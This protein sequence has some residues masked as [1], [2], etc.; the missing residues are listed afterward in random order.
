MKLSEL[1]REMESVLKKEGDL[2][3]WCEC[4]HGQ[5]PENVYQTGVSYLIEDGSESY[6]INE[7]DLKEYGDNYG[8]QVQRIFFIN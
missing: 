3:V 2:E 7:D 4:D 5:Q 6:Y 1:I 8:D